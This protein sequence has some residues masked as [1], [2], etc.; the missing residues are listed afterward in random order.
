MGLFFTLFYVLAAFL[1][2]QTI[3]GDLAEYHIQIVIA[4]I[5]LACSLPAAG[6]SGL[7]RMPQPYAILGLS[8]AVF[9]SL[10]FNGWISGG[11]IALMEFIPNAMAF[12]FVVLNC[13]KKSHLQMLVAVL[14]FGALFTVFRA[15]IALRANDLESPY[16]LLMSDDAGSQIIRI[17]GLS[18]ISDPNDLAQFM[19]GLIPCMFLFWSSQKKFANFLLVYLPISGLV[20]GMYLTHSRGG[21]VALLAVAIVAGRRKLGV[22]PSVIAG[23]VLFVGLSA[24]GFS[25]GREVSAASG[26]DR[27][28][29]WG[30]GLGLIRTHPL[31]GVGFRRFA[32]FNDITAHNTVVVCAAELGLVGFFF[33]MLFTL[34][35]VRDALVASADPNAEKKSDDEETENQYRFGRPALQP[36]TGAP[37]LP[38]PF[39]EPAFA[40]ANSHQSVPLQRSSTATLALHPAAQGAAPG[41][42]P[43]HPAPLGMEER[44]DSIT[45]EE[46]RRI[47]GLM[48]VS[49]AGFLTAGW[50]L[51]RAYVMTLFIN[52]GMAEVIY[53]M[54]R[55]RGIAAPILSIGRAMKL[56]LY[57]CT[58]FLVL[59]YLILRISH[60]LPK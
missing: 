13:K 10:A 53:R 31:F 56:S 4:L 36:T 34:P 16:L 17:R 52:A 51:S 18:F 23:V 2:P 44:A 15:W 37:L 41:N 20:Y 21:M 29:A 8:G 55:N 33:W 32:D 27:M 60:F 30:V 49:F 46:I 57:L 25:G 40:T 35:T 19:V 26:S 47:S 58:A 42:A 9:L 3:F 22:V 14:L 5:T 45:D 48:V 59:V 7:L 12:F 38:R 28:D 11:P 1:G 50:F 39:A 43:W 54:A 24:V 6:G